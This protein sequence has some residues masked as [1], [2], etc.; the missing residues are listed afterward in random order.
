[1]QEWK[2]HVKKLALVTVIIFLA[3]CATTE[4]VF[5]QEPLPLPDRPNL[6]TVQGDMMQC[7][8]DEAYEA[9]AVRDTMLQEHVRRLE[10]IIET[11]HSEE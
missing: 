6:P 2:R 3:G 7:L 10:A 5:V 11:T 4:P 9:L 8:S 1:M